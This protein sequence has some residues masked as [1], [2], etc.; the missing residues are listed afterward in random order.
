MNAG[1]LA[2]RVGPGPAFVAADVDGRPAVATRYRIAR[3]NDVTLARSKHRFDRHVAEPVLGHDQACLRPRCPVVRGRAQDGGQIA[4]RR[5]RRQPI[6]V[7][8]R[9]LTVEPQRRGVIVSIRRIPERTGLVPLL[10]S[11]TESTRQYP[12]FPSLLFD[13]RVP[14]RQEVAVR[15]LDDRGIVI[16]MRE[17][18]PDRISRDL[19]ILAR[20]P[21][22][23]LVGVRTFGPIRRKGLFH[24]SSAQRDRHDRLRRCPRHLT[25]H[26]TKSDQPV[27]VVR[28]HAHSVRGPKVIQ[29]RRVA[30]AACDT[31]VAIDAADRIRLLRRLVRS[32]PVGAP[33]LDIAVHVVEAPGVRRCLADGQDHGCLVGR[34]AYRIGE[35]T[36][37]LVLVVFVGE[38]VAG[39]EARGRTGAA[40]VFPFGL[41]RQPI[42]QSFLL[43][44]PLAESDRVVPAHKD[45]RLVVGLGVS[46]LTSKPSVF[47][48]ELFVLRVGY[49]AGAHIEGF[50][51][52]DPMHRLFV[53]VALA[54]MRHACDQ[55]RQR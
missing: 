17:H 53:N 35:P 36:P 27:S 21:E 1:D 25:E 19:D 31:E 47:R 6:E 23:G 54:T 10:L 45:H 8:D 52:R 14:D 4:P 22:I 16:V 37:P 46:E 32:V 7:I 55:L 24:V 28:E 51:D 34:S 18:R 42:G 5:R 49:F 15:A 33:L 48:I 30:P 43:R 41:G 26:H 40:G 39:V 3:Q 38:V 12:Q 29:L 44:Q 2:A 50:A 20:S 11:V 13:A 9:I